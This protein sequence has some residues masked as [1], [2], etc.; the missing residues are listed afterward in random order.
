MNMS[1]RDLIKTSEVGKR[2]KK[3]KAVGEKFERQIELT[4]DLYFSKGLAYIQKFHPDRVFI[5]AQKDRPAAMIYKKKTGFDFV[6][7]IARS[8]SSPAIAIFIETKSTATGYISV[9]DERIGIKKHQLEL[10]TKLEQ[11]G[12]DA[13]FLWEIRNAEV[14]YKFTA[15]M[16]IAAV[17]EQKGLNIVKCE[18]N[19]FPR[20]IK[21]KYEGGFMYDFL[22]LL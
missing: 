19:R 8:I 1:L 11:F 6:G 10:M 13:F 17:G 7:A 15:S 2:T 14:V 16:L 22:G 12:V 3:P 9:G 20:V 5:P 18:E 21:T 4:C